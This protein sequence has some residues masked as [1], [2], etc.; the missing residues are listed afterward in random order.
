MMPTVS[1]A[2]SQRTTPPITRDTV[3][4]RSCFSIA[5][6]ARGP[7]ARQIRPI[8][9]GAVLPDPWQDYREQEAQWRREREQRERAGTR[10]DPYDDPDGTRDTDSGDTGDPHGHDPSQARP[11]REVAS[12]G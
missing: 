2:T 10:A 7:S 5:L 11:A 3:G 1:P 6:Q 9:F 8:D 4:G 12:R